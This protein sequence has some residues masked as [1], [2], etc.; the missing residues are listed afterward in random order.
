MPTN[1][2]I[3]PKI[4]HIVLSGGGAILFAQV[5]ILYES[6][7]NRFWNFNDLQTTY[8]SSAGTM[9]V[10][11]LCFIKIIGWNAGIDYLLKRPWANVLSFSI[12][13][14]TN[15]FM[16]KGL[17]DVKQIEEMYR[18]LLRAIDKDVDI[19]LQE[20]YDIVKIDVHFICAEITEFKMVV[21]NRKT[22]PK[23]RLVD[24]IYCSCCLPLFFRPYVLEN[25]IFM[26]GSLFQ[27]FPIKSC[28]D[29]GALS[30]EILAITTASSNN[31]PEINH[32]LDY[33]SFT[34]SQL[35]EYVLIKQ[36]P[37]KYT[38][39]VPSANLIS[40]SDLYHIITD[41]K[42]RENKFNE[43][44]SLFGVCYSKW[45]VLQEISQKFPKEI[46]SEVSDDTNDT[47]CRHHK[48]T[49][50]DEEDILMTFLN[51]KRSSEKNDTYIS[52]SSVDRLYRIMDYPVGY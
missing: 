24:A 45:N 26:D 42:M 10:C 9:V 5:G 8:S 13:N 39:Y 7:V 14:L 1:L 31:V 3:S 2:P 18:P 17:F 22:H 52:S 6:Y 38:V 16:G 15:A 4:K 28:L 47:H 32:L 29:S 35:L 21:L 20:F 49:Q 43:G 25:K 51:Q 40:Y 41:A 27:H 37:V 34:L 19:T 50:A 33:L 12:E 44:A 11:V 23:W 48:E 36:P 30:D 46:A